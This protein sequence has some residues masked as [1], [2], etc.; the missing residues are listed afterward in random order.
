MYSPIK[1]AFYSKFRRIGYKKVHIEI[2][3]GGR[4]SSKL[5]G[6]LGMSLNFMGKRFAPDLTGFLVESNGVKPITIEVKR[7]SVGFKELFQAKGYGELLD[8][9][10]AFLVSNE[11]LSVDMKEALRQK[12]N[13]IYFGYPNVR[14]MYVGRFNIKNK[15][16]INEDWFPSSPF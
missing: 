6:A 7:K 8:A 1:D 10:Y 9:K 12:L 14:L 4:F 15:Q 3:S 11:P 13:L 5:K 2:T 16:I